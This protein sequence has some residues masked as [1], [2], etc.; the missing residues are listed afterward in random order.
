MTKIP[1]Q[2]SD[3]SNHRRL[4][5]SCCCYC[6]RCLNTKSQ[7]KTKMNP[8]R[9]DAA[10]AVTWNLR[11]ISRNLNFGL[12]LFLVYRQ[13]ERVGRILCLCLL[14]AHFNWMKFE[15]ALINDGPFFRSG[16]PGSHPQ[17]V[18][19]VWNWRIQFMD[20]TSIPWAPEWVSERASE[21]MSAAE[22]ASKAGSAE[23]VNEWA[24]RANERTEERMA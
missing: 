21:R 15:E 14:F 5:A 1:K 4:P 8:Q 17:W 23:Q 2:V 20:K 12:K 7:K 9:R 10:A 13:K 24:V 6:C 11:S 18:E 3:T 19:I 16:D 22:R